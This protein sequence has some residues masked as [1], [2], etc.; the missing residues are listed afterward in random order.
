[1]NTKN[2]VAASMLG[3]ALSVGSGTILFHSEPAF[4][5]DEDEGIPV[6]VIVVDEEGK[7]IQTAVVRHPREADRHRVNTFDGSW[8]ASTLYLPDGSEIKFTK[9]MEL[10]LE[11]SAPGYVNQHIKYLVRKRKNVFTVTLAKMVLENTDDDA[12]DP[13]IQFGRDKPIDGT[14]SSPR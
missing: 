4:A 6:K 3:F 9:G 7:P 12:D 2:I 11:I 13:V 1:M 14:S 10:E 5:G 8:E